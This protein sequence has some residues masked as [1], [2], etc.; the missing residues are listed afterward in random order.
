[1]NHYYRILG[2]IP[3]H[4]DI[5]HLH[6]TA[7]NFTCKNISS[8]SSAVN[9]VNAANVDKARISPQQDPCQN[10]KY[11][12]HEPADDTLQWGKI[13]DAQMLCQQWLVSLIVSL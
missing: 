4:D 10:C 6:F 11:Y 1:M 12:H 13:S 3:D 9:D 2:A 7:T 5:V 8:R